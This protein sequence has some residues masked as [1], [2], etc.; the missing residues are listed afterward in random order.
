M[1]LGAEDTQKVR[2]LIGLGLVAAG[3]VYVQFFSES[4]PNFV[5]PQRRTTAPAVRAA[6]RSIPAPRRRSAQTRGQDFEP[7]WRRSHEDDSFDPLTADPALRTDLLAAVREVDFQGVE[8]NIFQFGERKK[9]APPPPPAQITAAQRK[10]EDF[11]AR[12]AAAA[13]PPPS[14]EPLKP[15]APRITWKYYGLASGADGGDRRAFL[16]DGEDVLI[17]GEG[18][19]FKNR[20]KIIRISMTS[21]VVEDMQFSDQQTLPITVPRG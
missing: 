10:Q 2:L 6:P 14:A 13:P 21:I 1:K 12:A 15:R 4:E 11:A 17:G 8:R 19:V 20:Y 7:I 3:T 18:D 16:L 5:A 9:V